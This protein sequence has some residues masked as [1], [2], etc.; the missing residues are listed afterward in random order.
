M[1]MGVLL[2]LPPPPPPPPPQPARRRTR[3]VAQAPIPREF[4]N[5]PERE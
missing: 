4:M 3:L 2:E 5:V 1:Y